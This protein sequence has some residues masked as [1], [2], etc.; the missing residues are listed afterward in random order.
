MGGSERQSKCS[1]CL[2]CHYYV[3]LSSIKLGNHSLIRSVTRLSFGEIV[4]EEEEDVRACISIRWA[5]LA[6][7]Y[8]TLSYIHDI[9]QRF[10]GLCM[11]QTAL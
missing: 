10:S 3:E 2:I 8:P 11:S 6:C 9:L 5:T 7:H 1:L 4:W